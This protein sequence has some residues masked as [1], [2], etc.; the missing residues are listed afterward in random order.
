MKTFKA[1]AQA[2]QMGRT[3][4]GMPTFTSSGNAL[5]DLFSA[6]GSSR[7]KDITK[8]FAAAYEMDRE[9]ALKILLWG[10]D[11]RGGAGERQTVRN[12]LLFLEDK[13][14]EDA[15]MLVPLIPFFGRWDDLL[16]FRTRE[17][18]QN[19]YSVIAEALT[20][21]GV[22]GLVAK[23]MPRKGKLALELEDFLGLSPKARGFRYTDGKAFPGKAYRTML[24][25]LSNV[26]EQQMCAKQ[27]E[28]IKFDHIPSLASARYQK[29]FNRRCSER[30][31]EYK[32]SLVKGTAKI[33]ANAV[34]PYD[35]IKSI[36]QGD[37]AVAAAQWAALPNYLG[38]ENIMAMV[39]VSGSMTAMQGTMKIR[40]LDIAVSLGLYIADKAKGAFKDCFLTFSGSPTVEVL[41]GDIVSKYQQ[42]VRSHWGMNTNLMGA[43]MEILKI[44]TNN[45]VADVDM[46]KILLILSD[47]EFD[48]CTT[49]GDRRAM[50]AIQD[51][52]QQA[53]YTVP[54]IVFWNL[55][56]RAGNSPVGHRENGTALVSGFSPAIMKSIL[57]ANEVK[58]EN[59]TPETVME[60]TIANPR[61]DVID[62]KVALHKRRDAA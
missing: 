35:V 24:A 23:W 25:S 61:Y 33:N 28:E 6:I 42:M 40:N 22:S 10:R 20:D 49:G 39:D 17:M 32:A 7:G 55:N 62:K 53:G 56:A 57:T 2:P 54:K 27:W 36:S 5:V 44:G 59:F 1:A 9:K 29:A 16:V 19:A 30:Y 14:K 11:I 8:Q 12:L 34:Y 21:T 18:R 52:Y 4:N 41:T 31:K 50:V 58:A 45:G 43:F 60:Q 3:F 26:V 38:D 47:M 46:P 13:H 51:M 37:S 15:E 48:Q